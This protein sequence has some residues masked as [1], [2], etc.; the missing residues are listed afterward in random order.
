MNLNGARIH[1]LAPESSE[2]ANLIPE[3]LIIMYRRLLGL[4]ALACA[5][6]AQPPAFEVASVKK[7]EP[8]TPALV[9][10]GRLHMGVFLDSLHVRISQL[11][12]Y[13]LIAFA[14][15][16]KGRQ[17]SGP[18]WMVT[19]RYDIQARLPEGGKR[20]QVPAM[21]QTLLAERFGM[22]LHRENRDLNVYALVGANGGPHLK[23]FVPED[24]AP[25]TTESPIQGGITVGKG[26]SAVAA[27][28]SGNSKI[29]PGP[30]GNLHVENKNMTMTAF[31]DFI[32]RYSELPIID[33][34][35]IQGTYQMEFDVSAEEVRNAARAHGVAVPPP[36]SG[37]TASDPA[38]ASLAASLRK[39]GLRLESRK[40]P[41]EVLVID[42]VEKVP[43][44]N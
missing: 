6:F 9:Q 29:T 42:K 13:E 11:S 25:Q 21:M 28:P 22:R 26:G 36:A 41:T 8:I 37:E 27:G 35:G 7:A 14:Y 18:D 2:A 44:E 34:T 12:L 20:G 4:L 38:G 17:I 24:T 30:D 43:T 32:G 15:Q 23:P 16:V 3:E 39:L 33:F 40:A 31:A 10:S 19:E 5:S 1:R